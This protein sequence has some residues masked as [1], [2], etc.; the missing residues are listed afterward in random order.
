MVARNPHALWAEIPNHL[1]GGIARKILHGIEPG[2]FLGA[3]FRGDLQEA[4][5]RADEDSLRALGYIALFVAFYY[6]LNDIRER[7]PDFIAVLQKATKL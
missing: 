5:F 6:E 3:V 2:H 4:V 1:R 7:Y